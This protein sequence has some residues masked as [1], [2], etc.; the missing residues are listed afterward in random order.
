MRR[1]AGQVWGKENVTYPGQPQ[2]P[3]KEGRGA[4]AME[5]EPP[6]TFV[7]LWNN[8]AVTDQVEQK[9]NAPLADSVLSSVGGSAAISRP[10][11]PNSVVINVGGQMAANMTLTDV[12]KQLMTMGLF[13]PDLY[14]VGESFGDT[15][16]R[17]V[18]LV[19]RVFR[20]LFP[21]E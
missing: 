11:S 1:A 4:G 17:Y 20:H 5:T 6:Q 21:L 16:Q 9:N 3:R 7:A 8:Q 13:P 12:R 14:G 19:F 10:F 15:R 2:T 18:F